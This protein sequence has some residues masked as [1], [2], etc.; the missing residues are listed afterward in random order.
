MITPESAIPAV[1]RVQPLVIE[2]T[3]QKDSPERMWRPKKGRCQAEAR[4]ISLISNEKCWFQPTH[5]VPHESL[6]VSPQSPLEKDSVTLVTKAESKTGSPMT[7]QTWSKHDLNQQ[8]FIYELRKPSATELRWFHA[9]SGS[10]WCQ[11]ENATCKNA[12][13]TLGSI[14]SKSIFCPPGPSYNPDTWSEALRWRARG[15][16]LSFEGGTLRASPPLRS[17]RCVRSFTGTCFIGTRTHNI[18]IDDYRCI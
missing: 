5:F 10:N 17:A 8:K 16:V 9:S 15:Y 14:E 6:N 13:R 2:A 4:L 1:D 12:Y 3:S 7:Y 18:N 11:W